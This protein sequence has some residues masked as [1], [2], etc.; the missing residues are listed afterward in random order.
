LEKQRGLE[1]LRILENG[2]H[3]Q[4]NEVEN[5]GQEFWELNNPED[6]PRVE[7]ILEQLGLE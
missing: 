6:V 1:Q 4:S 5:P 7:R 2:S 3:V